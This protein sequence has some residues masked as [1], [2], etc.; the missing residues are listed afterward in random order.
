[1]SVL[2]SGALNSGSHNLCTTLTTYC[3]CDGVKDG[4]VLRAMLSCAA[5][6]LRITCSQASL[7]SARG[8]LMPSLSSLALMLGWC[9]ARHAGVPD[10]DRHRDCEAEHQARQRVRVLELRS[11]WGMR[12]AARGRGERAVRFVRCVCQPPGRCGAVA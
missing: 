11:G 4:C 12:H 1:M 6:S 10:P 9:C 2:F 7:R 8:L 3:T 5:S